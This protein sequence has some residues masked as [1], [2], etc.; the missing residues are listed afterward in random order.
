MKIHKQ[1]VDTLVKM[2]EATVYQILDKEGLGLIIPDIHHSGGF[3]FNTSSLDEVDRIC[4]TIDFLEREKLIDATKQPNGHAVPGLAYMFES[5]EEMDLKHIWFTENL[6]K[7][8]Y[9]RDLTINL[10][11]FNFIGK[12]RLW[13]LR[14]KTDKQLERF[15]R[16]WLPVGI[17]ILS[18][19]LTAILTK[20]IDKKF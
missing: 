18:S 16:F 4:F 19:G 11:I 12:K 2:R 7:Q 1:F 13:F 20:L 5:V 14:Y 15:W 17:A 9:G 10:D 6:L 8:N 3:R